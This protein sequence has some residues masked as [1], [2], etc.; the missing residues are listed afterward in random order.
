MG[1]K[2][3]RSRLVEG[4]LDA[5]QYVTVQKVRKVD[6]DGNIN[7]ERIVQPVQN[8][9]AE[10]KRKQTGAR[11]HDEW[12][13]HDNGVDDSK[14]VTETPHKKRVDEFLGA[15]LSR[16]ALPQDEQFCQSCQ[17]ESI[18][19]WR[20]KDCSLGCTMYWKC[21]RHAHIK[22]PFHRIEFWN[23]K[24]FRTA[25]LWEVGVAVIVPHYTGIRMCNNLQLQQRYLEENERVK[26]D[27]EQ[28]SLRQGMPRGNTTDADISQDCEVNSEQH[29]P[30]QHYAREEEISQEAL[31]DQRFFTYL[32]SLRSNPN[33]EPIEEPDDN[34][35]VGDEDG[36]EDGELDAQGDAIPTWLNHRTAQENRVRVLHTNGIHQISL[37]TCSCN[38]I[39]NIP[40][41]LI[42][43]R[44][45]PTSFIRIRTLFSAHLLDNFRL[46]NLELHASAYQFYHL[47]RR[48]TSPMNPAGVVDLYNEFC[49]MTRLW[50]W[51]KK[52][53]WAGYAGHNGKKVSE[54]ENGELANYCPA[55]PQ[56]G[57][58][59]PNNWEDDPNRFVYRRVLMADRNFK[60]DHVQP[61]KPSQDVW[62]SEGSGMIPKREEYHTFLKNTIKK[63]TVCTAHPK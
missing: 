63:L 57:V 58:N 53:K 29:K 54:V 43:C 17:M 25:E 14:T 20:C 38:G 41:D 26:D 61:K 8:C 51:T 3:K 59:L 48:V 11:D 24:S 30:R 46:A 4:D 32:D 10:Y 45:W 55:C 28:H 34:A 49:R 56:P 44:L 33:A 15:L 52:L 40:C 39:N 1:R 18:A 36:D 21:M 27:A 16:E 50:R 47:L 31:Q 6:Q 2:S 13:Y 35:K 9:R 5:A 7:V 42:A 23:G 60:A 62:L 37:V 22:E 12:E 19:V